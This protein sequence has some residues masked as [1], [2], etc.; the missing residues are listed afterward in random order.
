MNEGADVNTKTIQGRT[1]LMHAVRNENMICT[2][3]L[4]KAGAKVRQYNVQGLKTFDFL[5][6][7]NVDIVISAGEDC[8]MAGGGSRIVGMKNLKDFLNEDLW[9]NVFDVHM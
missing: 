6:S 2:Q 3:M 1:A 8:M 5:K 9:V 7:P 4:L